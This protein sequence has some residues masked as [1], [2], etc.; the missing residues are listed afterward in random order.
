MTRLLTADDLQLMFGCS[1]SMVYRMAK[2]EL[3]PDVMLFGPKSKRGMR[4]YQSTIDLFIAKRSVKEYEA[5]A[6]EFIPLTLKA[7]KKKAA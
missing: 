1:L 5:G 2:E 6:P 3:K 7:R 4:W